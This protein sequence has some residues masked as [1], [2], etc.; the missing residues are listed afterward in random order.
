M[1]AYPFVD[2]LKTPVAFRDRVFASRGQTAQ[3]IRH[4]ANGRESIEKLVKT[5]SLGVLASG[6]QLRD[7]P[8]VR[9]RSHSWPVIVR[10]L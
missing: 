10:E 3:L 7:G 8:I 5:Y 9:H 2:K 4:L 6:G 1:S